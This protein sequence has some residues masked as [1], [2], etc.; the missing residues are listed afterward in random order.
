MIKAPSTA[1]NWFDLASITHIKVNGVAVY[2]SNQNHTFEI[3]CES[4]AHA[5]TRAAELAA[6]VERAK[7]RDQF[8]VQ[9]LQPMLAGFFAAKG[10]SLDS[11]GPQMCAAAYKVADF[12]L[13]A[14]K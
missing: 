13:E 14:R 2:L 7:L 10:G 4:T 5:V 11:H 6:Q 3:V 1:G 8:A 12:M 9:A